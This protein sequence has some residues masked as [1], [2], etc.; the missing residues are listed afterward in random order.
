[1]SVAIMLIATVALLASWLS[2]RKRTQRALQISAK[3]LKGLVPGVLGMIALVGLVLALIPQDMLTKLFQSHGITSF[4]AIT[5]IGSIISM[6]S[7]I[8]FPLA[9]SLL[10]L[11][12]SPAALAAFITTLTMVGIITAPMEISYFGKRFTVVRQTLSFVTA[13][14]IGLLMGAFL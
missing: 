10:K 2:D 7:P 8:A 5:V 6:P 1:M 13:I 12:A 11:G 4:V 14:I 3:A 9:G